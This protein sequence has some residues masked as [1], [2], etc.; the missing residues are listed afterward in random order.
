MQTGKKI[1]IIRQFRGITQK[2]LAA[3]IGLGENAGNRITQYEIGYR[4]PKKD[5]LDKPIS[6]QIE[7]LILKRK[8]FVSSGED[9]VLAADGGLRTANAAFPI[10]S[11]G[12]ICGMFMLIKDEKSRP[13]EPE[14]NLR[15]ARL[16]AAFLGREAVQ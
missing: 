4:V 5:L 2:E 3:A 10:L 11:E 13:G 9:T 7:E 8:P 6:R 15:L 16:A 1:R 12:D 14:E